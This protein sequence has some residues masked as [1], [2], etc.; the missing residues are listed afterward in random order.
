MNTDDTNSTDFYSGINSR[1]LAVNFS[2]ILFPFHTDITYTTDI[3][4]DYFYIDD[5]PVG[6][7]CL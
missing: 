6:L 4:P 5:R 7:L 1:N 3:L 2:L